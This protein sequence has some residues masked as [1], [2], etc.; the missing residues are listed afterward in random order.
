MTTSL[1]QDA[2]VIDTNI[3]EHLL[4][5]KKNKEGH[6][7][8]LLG[9]LQEKG[10]A[11]LVDDRKR[12]AGEYGD[13]IVPIIR[14]T[15]DTRNEVHILRYWIL[16]APR[17][18]IEIDRTGDLMAA[19]KRVIVERSEVVDRIFVYVAF[20]QGKVLVSND[21]V[22]ILVGPKRESGK[23]PRRQRLLQ[24]FKK[25]RSPGSEILSSQEA[26]DGT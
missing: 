24:N 4:N 6:I 19:I 25:L 1:F 9:H 12:I 8:S 13:R 5:P 10:V 2:V 3:F 18:C 17:L 7:N 22:H 11:L 14:S 23:T 21:D 26:Y 15:D 16:G 20:S